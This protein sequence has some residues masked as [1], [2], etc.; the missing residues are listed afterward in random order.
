MPR[1]PRRIRPIERLVAT[2]ITKIGLKN[3]FFSGLLGGWPAARLHLAQG[4]HPYF[5]VRTR[6][7]DA[8]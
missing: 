1:P 3:R 6:H 7:R 4:F 5:F 2:H 8:V